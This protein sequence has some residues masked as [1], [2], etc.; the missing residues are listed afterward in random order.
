MCNRINN[1]HSGFTLV[2]LLVVIGIIAVLIGILLPALGRARGQASTVACAANLRSIGQAIHLYVGQ[3]KGALP[4]GYWDGIGSP[5]G[6]NTSG[7]NNASDWQLLLMSVALGKGGSTYGTQAGADTS[8][9]QDAFA[10]P[11]ASPDSGSPAGNISRKLHYSSHP[12]IMPTLDEYDASFPPGLR[13]L[14][15]GWKLSKVR[16]SSQMVLIFDAAQAFGANR[17]NAW[18]VGV[19]I[20]EGGL[21]ARHYLL[22]RNAVLSDSVKVVDNRDSGRAD[23]R[24]RHGKNNTANFLFADGHAESKQI[25]ASKKS[26]LTLSNVCVDQ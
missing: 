22:S 8:K 3:N 9:L 4:Y 5:D 6:Q 12:R 24:W 25:S 13:P 16:R 11:S 20:D 21:K 10:C 7:G 1:R 2:E 17:G 19:D 26:D 23:I 14:L 15:K 18:A